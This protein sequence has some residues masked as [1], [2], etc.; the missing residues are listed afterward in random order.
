MIAKNR[1]KALK[2]GVSN[3]QVF[4]STSNTVESQFLESISQ[5]KGYFPPFSHNDFAPGFVNKPITR[6]KWVLAQNLSY[7]KV[8]SLIICMKVNLDSF[9]H[10]GKLGNSVNMAYVYVSFRSYSRI[11]SFWTYNKLPLDLEYIFWL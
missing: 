5:T 8:L 11:Q 1:N 7:G 2:W 6:P 4:Y 9:W 10:W 3:Q